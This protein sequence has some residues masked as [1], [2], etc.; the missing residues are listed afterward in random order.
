[1]DRLQWKCPY[2]RRNQSKFYSHVSGNYAVIVTQNSC[3]DTSACYNITTV[4]VLDNS[5]S[6][7]I[8]IY[9]NPGNGQITVTGKSI[10]SIE[11]YNVIGEKIFQS[12]INNQ[13]SEIDLSNQPYGVYFMKIYERQ[14]FY[15]KKVVIE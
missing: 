13:Q 10:T 8:T 6:P 14:A 7:A 9:P 3:S 2:S 15:T 5:P 4:G 12:S 1:M 11:I